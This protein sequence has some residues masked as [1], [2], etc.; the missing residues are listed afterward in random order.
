MVTG[1]LVF[2]AWAVHSYGSVRA[3]STLALLGA[4]VMT[5]TYLSLRALWATTGAGV[6]ILGGP[7]GRRPVGIS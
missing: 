2:T 5:G 3:A 1:V 4:V 7:P 6:L